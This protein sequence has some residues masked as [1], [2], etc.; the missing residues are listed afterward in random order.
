MVLK[1]QDFFCS[2][3]RLGAERKLVVLDKLHGDAPELAYYVDLLFSHCC[4]LAQIENPQSPFAILSRDGQ[5]K[6]MDIAFAAC[7]EID[8]RLR[9]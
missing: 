2:F 7:C 8:N 6:Q 1:A 3:Q 5:I 4:I 9:L